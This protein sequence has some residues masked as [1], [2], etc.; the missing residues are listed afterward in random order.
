MAWVAFDRAIKA[1]R[2]LKLRAPI[3]RWSALKAKIHADVCRNAYDPRRKSFMQY[4]GASEVDASLLL[5]PLVGFL[6]P[7]DVR[8]RNTIAAI[9]RDLMIDGL[10]ARYYTVPDVDGLPPGEGAF[11]PCSFWLVDNLGLAGRRAEAV[12]LFNRLLALRNDV[13]L[14]AEEYDPLQRRQLGNFPQALTHV[15]IIN[16]ACSLSRRGGPSEHRSKGM[17]G[18]PPGGAARGATAPREREASRK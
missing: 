3:S 15:A 13:G 18:A 16:S 17:R 10:V 7:T 5:M 1:A 6:P 8:V 12:A 9:E 4:Y 11:L 2:Q 14:I